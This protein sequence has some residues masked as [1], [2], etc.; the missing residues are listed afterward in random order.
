[1]NKPES[2]NA[3]S[4]VIAGVVILLCLGTAYS[5]GIFLFPI[6]HDMGWGRAAIAS[7][8]SVLLLIFSI[9]MSIG[10]YCERKIGPAYTAALGGFLVA[11]GW[12]LASFAR[13]PLQL[14]LSYGLLAG[15]GTGL[16]YISAISSG[17]KCFPQKKGFVTGVI[18]SG[19]GFGTALLAPF[20]TILIETQGWRS[21]MLT[22]GVVFGIALM[23][24]ARFLYSPPAQVCKDTV[25]DAEVGFSSRKMIRTVSFRVM[26]LT[27][28][29]AMVAGLITV[30]HLVSFM[31]DRGFNAMQGAYALTILSICNGLGRIFFGYLSDVRGGRRTLMLLFF[32][33]IFMTLG[34]CYAHTLASIYFFAGG[35]GFLLGGFLATYPVLTADHFGRRNF[36]VNY[37]LVF[38]G[39]G[40]GCFLGPLLGGVV[41]DNTQDYSLAFY[42]AAA[43]AGAG[44]FLVRFFLKHPSENRVVV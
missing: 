28:F 26:F 1:M 19:F 23:I 3:R 5:W 11:A 43:F 34:L 44:L 29:L 18:T 37:G 12:I 33:S 36:A 8:V 4:V 24:A 6:H 2:V 35:V 21:A 32:M 14:Y 13:T 31:L 15:I 38:I 25:L 27:Y 16:C 17:V 30:G 42:V 10:G 20:I 7:A 39:Y 9:F 22:C 41:Y 40:L